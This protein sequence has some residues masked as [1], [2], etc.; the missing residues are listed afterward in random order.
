MIACPPGTCPAE[1]AGLPCPGATRATDAY[2]RMALAGHGDRVADE[3]RR[4]AGAAADPA[5]MP[6]AYPAAPPDHAAI[7]P[8]AYPEKSPAE[9]VRA[10]PHRRPIGC[11]CLGDHACSL[12]QIPAT[13]AECLACVA[14]GDPP[15]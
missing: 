4:L 14:D 6:G 7:M 8:G 3:A 9:R 15:A 5:I 11:A 2:C 10:C 12:Y 13:A 1:L